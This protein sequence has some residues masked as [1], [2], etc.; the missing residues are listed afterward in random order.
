[1]MNIHD[2]I[3]LQLYV[4][5]YVH[6]LGPVL[7]SGRFSLEDM[8][9]RCAESGFTLTASELIQHEAERHQKSP[10][11]IRRNIK[12]YL[13]KAPFYFTND[14]GLQRWRKLGWNGKTPLSPSNGIPLICQGFLPYIMNYHPEEYSRFISLTLPDVTYPL[15]YLEK[16]EQESEEIQRQVSTGEQPV[17]EN[18]YDLLQYIDEE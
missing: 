14:I 5:Q 16:L 7:C 1:M 6:Y 18:I 2:H 8:I 3:A 10:N 11:T 13:K 4:Q 12:V 15:K 9:W 17:F